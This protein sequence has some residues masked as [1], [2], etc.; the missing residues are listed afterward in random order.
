MNRTDDISNLFSRFGASADSYHEFESQVDYKEKQPAPPAETPVSRPE[1]PPKSTVEMAPVVADDEAVEVG[2]SVSQLEHEPVSLERLDPAPAVEPSSVSAASGVRDSLGIQQAS[3]PAAIVEVEDKAVIADASLKAAHPIEEQP[4]PVATPSTAP[5]QLRNLLAEVVQARQAHA[6][7][8]ADESLH[9]AAA[10]GRPVKCKAH[11]VAMVSLKG[12][13]GKTTLGA[14]LASSF[15]LERGRVF[16]LDLDPQNALHYH[17]GVEQGMPGIGSLSSELL[18][19]SDRLQHGFEDALLLPY[20][21]LSEDERHALAVEMSEDPHWLARQLD[22]MHLGEGDVVIIDTA[23]GATPS[24]DQALDVA[25]EV[26][27][28]T[29]ADAASFNT[30]DLM[31]RLLAASH[32]R[33]AYSNCSYVVNQFDASREFSRDMLEVLKRRLGEQLIAVVVKDN[34]LGEA[35]AYGR[36]PLS[37]SE[38]SAACEDLV[39]LAEKLKARFET[40]R[41]QGVEAQ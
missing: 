21:V 18:T 31:E 23:T 4:W 35:L 28:V 15:R 7:A 37:V 8:L 38:P 36:N 14:G 16:A 6:Q 9:H 24:L 17:L 33:A 11:I 40:S 27:V 30:L 25:D 3:V 34:A 26:I 5:S 20:G 13:V 32:A 41:A 19:W 29:T 39:Q 12:G 2:Q 10:R 22:R 1:I